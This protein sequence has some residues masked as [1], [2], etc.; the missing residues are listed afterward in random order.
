MWEKIAGGS[1]LLLPPAT[2]VV[3][4]LLHTPKDA[5][6][7]RGVKAAAFDM[8][9]TLIAP[10]S[11]G[12]FAKDDAAD[13]QWVQPR[14]RGHVQHVYA[15]GFLVVLF[16]N[17]MGIGKGPIWRAARAEAVMSMIVQLSSAPCVPLCAC[18]ATRGD[19]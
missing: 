1:V 19:V 12:V 17:E 9:D 14:V 2:T 16:S 6:H 10:A 15:Q 8:S 11:G 3:Q 5:R 7:T 4:S 18:V 13:W